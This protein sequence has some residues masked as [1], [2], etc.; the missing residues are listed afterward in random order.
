[1]FNMQESIDCKPVNAINVVES[2]Q[3][4]TWLV[5]KKIVVQEGGYCP[6]GAGSPF[7]F[8]FKT[9]IPLLIMMMMLTLL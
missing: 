8:K 1:M 6:D 3:K 7:K 4:Q 2:Y 5:T 9:T